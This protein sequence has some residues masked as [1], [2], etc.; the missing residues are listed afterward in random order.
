[1]KKTFNDLWDFIKNTTV[2]EFG[3]YSNDNLI[4]KLQIYSNKNQCNVIRI[5][6]NTP[7]CNIVFD[8]DE[9]NVEVYK[10]RNGVCDYNDPIISTGVNSMISS[11]LGIFGY[12]LY[13]FILSLLNDNK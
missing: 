7:M 11:M 9:E 8:P 6:D 1:M 2:D 5:I 10:V 12:N 4:Y 3:E 13:P